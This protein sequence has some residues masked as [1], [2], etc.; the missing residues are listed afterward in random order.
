[1][2][3]PLYRRFWRGARPSGN[4]PRG[5]VVR[6]W[7]VDPAR[8]RSHHGLLG[9][10]AGHFRVADRRCC[11]Q[12][13]RV[14]ILSSNGSPADQRTSSAHALGPSA[15]APHRA[16]VLWCFGGRHALELQRHFPVHVTTHTDPKVECRGRM[17]TLG[18]ADQLLAG[19]TTGSQVDAA[20]CVDPFYVR[21]SVRT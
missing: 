16:A 6:L 18:V 2:E 15:P 13:L 4:N 19:A 11:P 1:M 17:P 12:R 8:L 9:N 3:V 5:C 14:E 21:S 7:E 10:D 20:L